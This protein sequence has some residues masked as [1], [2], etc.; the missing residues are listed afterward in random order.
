MY[1]YRP[2]D[3]LAGGRSQN[4]L[5]LYFCGLDAMSKGFGPMTA[6]AR[7][8]VEQMAQASRLAQAYIDLA[9]RVARNPSPQESYAAQ[10]QFW[11]TAMTQYQLSASQAMESWAK[12]LVPLAGPVPKAH[13]AGRPSRAIAFPAP[14]APVR[15][16][17]FGTQDRVAA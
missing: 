5:Q 6:I 4:P 7:I 15:E 12:M 10:M 11:Q 3:W 8:Q 14:R 2:H 9:S 13:D 16:P 17:G 1:S